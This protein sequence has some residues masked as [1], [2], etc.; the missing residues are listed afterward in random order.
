MSPCFADTFYYLA[1]ANPHDE[2]HDRAKAFTRTLRRRIVT[3]EFVLLEVA[4]AM[5]LP[6]S[7]PAFLRLLDVQRGSWN[8]EIVRATSEL[9]QR[10]VRLFAERPDKDWPLTDC[11]SFVVMRERGLTVT[12]ALTAD[13]HFEQGGFRALLK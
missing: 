13:H 2:S 9:F 1:L 6:K 7:R 3:T 12:D 4:D 11:I 5:S 10:G 8:V